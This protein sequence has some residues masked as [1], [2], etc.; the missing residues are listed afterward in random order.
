MWEHVV[1]WASR[2]NVRQLVLCCAVVAGVMCASLTTRAAEPTSGLAADPAVDPVIGDERAVTYHPDH[3][4]V[5]ALPVDQA[6]GIGRH[7]FEARFTRLDGV[8]RPAATQSEIPTRRVPGNFP[9]FFRTSGPEANSC[10]G[11]HNQPSVGGAGDFV[12]N[13]F[14]SDGI[15]DADFDSLDPQFSNERGTVA[16][17][18][19]GFVELLAREMTR[20]LQAQR[21]A[22]LQQART[23]GKSQRVA[24]TSK[25]VSFGFVTLDPDGFVDIREIQG[26]D[27][28]LVIRPFSQ[29]GVFSSLRQF[30]INALNAHHGMQADERYGAQWTGTPDFDGDGKAKEISTGDVTALVLFQASLPTPVRRLPAAPVLRAAV[31]TGK[32]VFAEV[33]CPTCHRTSLPLT[34]SIFAEPNPLNTAGTLRPSETARPALLQL[35]RSGFEKNAAGQILVPLFSDLKRHRI[36]DEDHPYFANELLGQR[37]VGRDVFITPRLWG[38][39][40]TAPYGHRGDLTTLREAILQHGGEAAS[41]RKAFEGRPR[42]DRNAV[43][44]F[45][46]H[47]RLPTGS[48]S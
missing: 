38:V 24:L 45:L 6:I 13:V 15:S 7:L 14:V 11:C 44:E 3:A 31:A 23:T 43:I 39:G 32:Q 5:A 34:S 21:Q 37:F 42:A 12:A 19:A 27:H 18:G 47:L 2:S 8:G 29:K 41:A 30:T 48:A 40:D 33:G 20:E 22:G 17:N 4:Q 28:D 35:D 26:V 25:G 10:R 16:I 9:P 46:K 36:A 1:S